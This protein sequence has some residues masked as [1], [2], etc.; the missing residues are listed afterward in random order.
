MESKLNTNN[1]DLP[2][3]NNLIK[4]ATHNVAT[5]SILSAMNIKI[6]STIPQ[7]QNNNN[8][9]INSE[10]TD[11]TDSSMKTEIGLLLDRKKL[12]WNIQ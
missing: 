11:T 6:N 8:K 9:K 12:L 10:L 7:E 4:T 5:E 2:L 3:E 1:L